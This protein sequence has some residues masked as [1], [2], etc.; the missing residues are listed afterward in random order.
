MPRKPQRISGLIIYVSDTMPYIPWDMTIHIFG[1]LID[2]VLS[3]LS[4]HEPIRL[5]LR[6]RGFPFLDP[7]PCSDRLS[8]RFYTRRRELPRNALA[9][10]KRYRALRIPLS[11]CRETRKLLHR[12]V[13]QAHVV[14]Y[15]A[16]YN[17]ILWYY[18][19]YPEF[20][21]DVPFLIFP[22]VDKFEIGSEHDWK[23]ETNFMHA[24]KH[25]SPQDRRVMD[26]A[27][28]AHRRRKGSFTD[29]EAAQWDR[30]EAIWKEI[31]ESRRNE[32][33]SKFPVVLP[34]GERTF[35]FLNM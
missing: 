26:W 4:S 31:E 14:I 28:L 15:A 10:M 2:E 18:S 25:A 1:L 5:K 9:Q 17:K 16:T 11:V 7:S 6:S 8:V 29:E 3:S 27:W 32:I 20:L 23:P 19:G 35:E 22:E 12:R 24:L 34:S 13:L 21:R 33:L 30:R